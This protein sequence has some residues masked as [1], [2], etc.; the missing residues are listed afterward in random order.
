M[1]KSIAIVAGVLTCV[2][3][4]AY[5][6]ESTAQD[7]ENSVDYVQVRNGIAY[8]VNETTPF[9]G[10]LTRK[11][12][13]GQNA[14]HVRFANG[15]A[16]GAETTYYPNGQVSSTINYKDGLADGDWKQ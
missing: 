7:T 5:A 8:Q 3:V 4:G 9:T 16:V 11:Y 13:S 6:T 12:N 2:S 14:L 10:E 1:R 15:K